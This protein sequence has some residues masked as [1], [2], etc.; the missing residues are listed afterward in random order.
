MPSREATMPTRHDRHL[1]RVLRYLTWQRHLSL[2]LLEPL[3]A[4]GRLSADQRG[5]AVFLMVAG[6]AQRPVGAELRGTGSRIW[7]GMAPGSSKDG[8]YF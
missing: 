8:G 1:P 6:K 4:N 3:L 5:N 2:S 7:R